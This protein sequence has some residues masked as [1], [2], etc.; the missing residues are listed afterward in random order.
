MT[1]DGRGVSQTKGKGAYPIA[2]VVRP[3]VAS[4]VP[5]PSRWR[6]ELRRDRAGRGGVPCTPGEDGQM[7]HSALAAI[8]AQAVEGRAPSAS[9]AARQR[10]ASADEPYQ[11]RRIGGR[12]AVMTEP[13]CRAEPSREALEG[14]A[15]R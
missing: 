8:I 3:R 5:S 15:D 14:D 9:G 12:R 11:R 10:I 2:V 13:P 6:D 4:G 1:E 7:P